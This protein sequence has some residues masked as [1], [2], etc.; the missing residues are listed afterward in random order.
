VTKITAIFC[1][2]MQ[3]VEAGGKQVHAELDARIP[4]EKHPFHHPWPLV[5]RPVDR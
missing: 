2:Q 4:R 1:C 5:D 3:D